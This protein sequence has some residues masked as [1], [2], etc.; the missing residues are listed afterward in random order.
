MA[1]I[2]SE[3][4][5]NLMTEKKELNDALAEATKDSLRSI[6]SESVND[7]IRQILSE[8]K[9][10][11]EE[12]EVTTDEIVNDEEK[13]E[14][15]TGT[16]EISAEET[17]EDEG[18]KESGE[19]ETDIEADAEI[20]GD[21]DTE[22]DELWASLEDYKDEDGE[23]DLTGMD[24]DSAVNIVKST[25][26]YNP[27]IRVF[28]AAKPEDG[29]NVEKDGDTITLTDN[30]NGTEYVLELGDD[31]ELDTLGESVDL[32]YT[33]DYQKDSAMTMDPD[34]GKG[35]QLDAGAPKGSE[36]NRK[37]WVGH[38]GDMAPYDKEVNECG[39]TEY[40]VEMD[41]CSMTEEDSLDEMTTVANGSRVHGTKGDTNHS[42]ADKQRHI[43]KD[44]QRPDDVAE[45]VNAKL[46][47]IMAENKEL[48]AIASQFK[49][50]LDEAVVINASLAK[51]IKL[52]TENSTTK[53]EKLEIVKRFNGAKTV[54]ECRDLYNRISEELQQK[55]PINSVQGINAQPITEAKAIDKKD[56]I[57]ETTLLESN[58]LSGTIDLMKRLDKIK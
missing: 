27:S 35:G 32:G 5:R 48:K 53:D 20:E 18:D 44:Y 58:E 50:K 55:H 36:N 39:E 21:D 29:I 37:P 24:V 1:N 7:G 54:N 51:I 30:N 11:Y 31:D 8:A 57:V 12:E 25:Q 2:R 23:Y 4:I 9:D 19:E 38:K 49:S 17:A 52:V 46:N 10:K 13:P 45:S 40:V 14:E 33:D 42:V 22:G 16:E 3:Y 6:L 41:E 15:E 26:D 43:H 56:M 28:T 34:D 47:K